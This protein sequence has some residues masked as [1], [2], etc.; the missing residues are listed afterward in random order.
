MGLGWIEGM[1]KPVHAII[2][3][4]LRMSYTNQIRRQIRNNSNSLNEELKYL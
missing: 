1:P 3:L 4:R 2:S